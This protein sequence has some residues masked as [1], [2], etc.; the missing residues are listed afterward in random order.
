MS[1]SD[2][3]T[4]CR[5]R[6]IGNL[7]GGRLGDSAAASL[8]VRRPPSFSIVFAVSMFVA[9][10]FPRAL[11][12]DR[13]KKKMQFLLSACFSYHRSVCNL[14]IAL[15][16]GFPRLS[17]DWAEVLNYHSLRPLYGHCC[18]GPFFLA[19]GLTASGLLDLRTL[20]SPLSPRFQPSRLKPNP[21][22]HHYVV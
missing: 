18:N 8:L 17:R 13:R 11:A 12:S 19:Y 15:P 4:G 21:F 1:R 20:L 9:L 10:V 7:L 14:R 2:T 6:G 16:C 22:P 3:A 5:C